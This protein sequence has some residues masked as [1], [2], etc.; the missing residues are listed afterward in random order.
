MAVSDNFRILACKFNKKEIRQRYFSVNCAK[1][2]RTSFNRMPA[3][4][5]FLC[6][7]VNFEK[8]SERLFYKCL[9]G[10]CLFH[11]HVA[12]FQPSNTVKNYFTGAFQ[13]FYQRTG[14][15]LSKV[16]IYLKYLK[17][18]CVKKLI[19]DE[20]A[21]C[22]LQVYEKTLSHILLHGFCLHFLRTHHNFSFRRGFE[23][24]RAQFLSGNISKK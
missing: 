11:V 19:R 10:N 15:S 3:D 22:N 16:F 8:F 4:D 24:V 5:C 17:T 9:L 14:S 20:V 2:L 18:T 13:A 12:E 6:L 23:C 1:F 7:P 21:K